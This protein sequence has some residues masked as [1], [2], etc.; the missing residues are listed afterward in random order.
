MLPSPPHWKE[1]E[2]QVEGGNT[3]EPMILFYRDA[4]E[5]FKFT[6]ANPLFLN[7]MDYVPRHE[8]ADKENKEQLYNEMMTGDRAWWLQV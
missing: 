3:K 1:E 4:L 2:V 7:H 8:Y 6:F 5:C